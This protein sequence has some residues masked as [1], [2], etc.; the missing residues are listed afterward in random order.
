MNSDLAIVDVQWAGDDLKLYVA[1]GYC[2]FFLE[3]VDGF[4]SSGQHDI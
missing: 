1:A 3:D 2:G 4:S